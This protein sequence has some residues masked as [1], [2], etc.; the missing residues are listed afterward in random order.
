MVVKV[1]R[2]ERWGFLGWSGFGCLGYGHRSR[3]YALVF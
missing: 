3:Y 1:G 2:G